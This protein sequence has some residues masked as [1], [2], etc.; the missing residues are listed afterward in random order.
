[1]NLSDTLPDFNDNSFDHR[2]IQEFRKRPDQAGKPPIETSKAGGEVWRSFTQEEK[3]VSR[4][5][6]SHSLIPVINIVI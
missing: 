6:L 1:M 4:L 5:L 3:D 2:F